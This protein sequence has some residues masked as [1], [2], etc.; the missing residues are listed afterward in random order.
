VRDVH[1]I[2]AWTLSS[3]RPVLTLH[4]RLAE[5]TEPR[6]ALRAIKLRLHA[7]FGFDHST[8]QVDYGD[9]PD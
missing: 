3:D 2:H 8:V 4:V 7:R 6:A 5:G 1:H 9:C